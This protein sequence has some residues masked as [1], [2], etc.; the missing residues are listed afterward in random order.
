[1]KNEISKKIVVLY[2]IVVAILTAT[3]YI[4]CLFHSEYVNSILFFD[5]YDTFSDFF[6]SVTGLGF[7]GEFTIYNEYGRIQYPPVTV[8]LFRFFRTILGQDTVDYYGKNLRMLRNPLML[9]CVY[10]MLILGIIAFSLSARLKFGRLINSLIIFILFFSVPAIFSIERGNIINLS[11][12]LSVFFLVFYDDPN[13]ILKEISFMALAIAA[14]LKIYPAI[15][16]LIL[17]SERK[18]KDSIKLFVYGFL[19]FILPFI[20]YG[21]IKAAYYFFKLA[22][23]YSSTL[24]QQTTQS[25]DVA[26]IGQLYRLNLSQ[27]QTKLGD[28]YSSN[29]SFMNIVQVFEEMLGIKVTHSVNRFLFFFVVLILL[30]AIFILKEKWEKLLCCGMIMILAQNNSPTYVELFILP[31]FV[32]FVEHILKKDEEESERSSNSEPFFALIIA[33]LLI[34]WPTGIVPFF[35]S[36]VQVRELYYS[37]LVYYVLFIGLICLIVYKL[38]DVLGKNKPFI[39]YMGY[40][41]SAVFSCFTIIIFVRSLG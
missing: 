5:R 7:P 12:A 30:V 11:F 17:L 31:S 27:S 20:P 40:F 10:N 24:L 8:A 13:K 33:A 32:C 34:P 38:V 39:K 9:F 28:S 2:L 35:D 14:A 22:F 36:K 23:G 3:Y 26:F 25:V 21:G 41:I 18:Y 37:Y 6:N 4:I 19:W 1:M 16:G 15:F 29:F